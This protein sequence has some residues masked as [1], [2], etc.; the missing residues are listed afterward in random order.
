MVSNEAMDMVVLFWCEFEQ[1]V[2]SYL[3]EDGQQWLKKSVICPSD[4][5]VSFVFNSFKEI[6]TQGSRKHYCE[7]PLKLVAAAI[8]Y[9]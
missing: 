6:F 1:Y 8:T 4:S 2:K 3:T 7:L 5:H 9:G